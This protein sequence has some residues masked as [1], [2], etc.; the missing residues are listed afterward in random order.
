M[1]FF[2]TITIHPLSLTLSFIPA[3]GSGSDFELRLPPQYISDSVSSQLTSSEDAVFLGSF[4]LVCRSVAAIDGAKL[5]LGLVQVRHAFPSEVSTQLRDQYMKEFL[6][7]SIKLIGAV[8][9]LG[10]PVLC[11]ILQLH[12]DTHYRLVLFETC[13]WECVIWCTIH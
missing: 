9:A 6:W 12:I 8:E 7:Q 10:D 1:I 2:D 11:F 4:E 3:K 5:E 13:S